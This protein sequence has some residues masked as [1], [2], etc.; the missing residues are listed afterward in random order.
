MKVS[1]HID[2][3]DSSN[4]EMSKTQVLGSGAIL[5][6]LVTFFAKLALFLLYHR[7]FAANR[8]GKDRDLSRYNSQ[9]SRL[10]RFVHWPYHSLNSKAKRELDLNDIRNTVLPCRS[11]GR[12]SGRLWSGI[13]SL[14]LHSTTSSPIP[15]TDVAQEEVRNYC[16]ISHGFDVRVFIP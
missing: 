10:P 12:R 6:S 3:G 15:A 7:L 14:Y 9:W 8:W 16:G 5:Y 11:D 1:P 13:G 2:S 4:L